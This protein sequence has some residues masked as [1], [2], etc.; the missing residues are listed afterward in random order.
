MLLFRAFIPVEALIWAVAFLTTGMFLLR[1]RA[2]YDG[3]F[4]VI[5]RK[6][7]KRLLVAVGLWVLLIASCFLY[8]SLHPS[9]LAYLG[10]AL[11]VLWYF[12]IPYL[13]AVVSIAWF[14]AQE[15]A[16]LGRA[17]TARCK[18]FNQQGRSG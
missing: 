11:L 6:V 12:Y 1:G 13:L 14:N 10:E 4:G 3:G 16:K 17:S 2:R 5:A 7:L 18:D 8:S 15:L 9:R